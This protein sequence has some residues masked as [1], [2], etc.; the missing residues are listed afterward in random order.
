[1]QGKVGVWLIGVN[2][3]LATTIIFGATAIAR[4]LVP[5]I[6]MITERDEFQQLGLLNISEIVFGGHDIR[7]TSVFESAY[8]VY[9]ETGT[10]DYELLL[11]VRDDL[12]KV[13][14]DVQCG[15]T[16]NCGKAIEG[17]ASQ[18][19]LDESKT[20]REW[21]LHL[22]SDLLTFKERNGLSHV[23]V[24]NVAS[25][26]PILH[27]QDER[28]NNLEGFEKILDGNDHSL[29][30]ASTLY[31]FSAIDLGF[32]YIN[33]TASNAPLIPAIQEL[34]EKRRAPFMGSDGKTGETMLKS[35]IAPMFKYR[36]L[37]VMSWQGYNILG[38]GDG[39]ILSNEESKA[40][41]VQRKDKAISSILGYPLHTHVGIDYVPS[42]NDWKTAWDY[43]HFKGFLG[44]KMSMQFIW[45][46]CDSI[47]AAPLVLDMIRFADFALKKGEYG[48]MKHLACFFKDPVG[49]ED[50]DL[51]H[52]FHMLLDYVKG[53]SIEP[54]I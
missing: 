52:Q 49:V 27:Q 37:H 30:R 16:V 36:N 22:Q 20:L 26:E 10:L 17:L 47:L 9:K 42:L 43:I 46:G 38:D 5:A 39:K 3:G 34:A 6:G 18:G 11:K 7:K 31:A 53:H 32:P 25:T 15:T 48:P 28:Y 8:E 50:H 29:I 13:D 21:V 35:A 2:G 41:K 23:I 44:V 54:V 1:M 12:N 19:D 4:N 14:R 51:H 33:F 45:Q 40:S 24:I